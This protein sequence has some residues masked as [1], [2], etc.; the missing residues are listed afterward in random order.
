MIN[1]NFD[2]HIIAVVVQF[3]CYYGCDVFKSNLY[4]KETTKSPQP[5]QTRMQDAFCPT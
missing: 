5:V 4:R 2:R 1:I 3:N